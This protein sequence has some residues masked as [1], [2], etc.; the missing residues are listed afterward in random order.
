MTWFSRLRNWQ[1]DASNGIGI[2]ADYHDSEDDNFATGINSSLNIAGLNSP[3]A[4]IPMGGFKFTG[5]TSGTATGDSATFG[6]LRSQIQSGAVKWGGVTTGSSNAYVCSLSPAL[7]S[8]TN[9]LQLAVQASFTNSGAA[10]INVDGL[11]AKNIT[12]NGTTSLVANDILINGVIILTYDGTEFQI[13]VS[14]FTAPLSTKGDLFTFDGSVN[15]R[16]PIGSNGQ[17]LLADS[18]QTTGNKWG[19]VI[20]SVSGTAPISS[21]TT[22]GA[23]TVTY[24][25]AVTSI[26]GTTNIDASYNGGLVVVTSGT[27][28]ITFTAAATLTSGFSVSITNNGTGVVTL[29]PN[30]SETIDTY[31]TIQLTQGQSVTL[32]CTGSAFL[33]NNK[34]VYPTRTSRQIFTSGSAQTWTVP[35]GVYRVYVELYGGGGGGCTQNTNY[36]GGGG[37]GGYCDVIQA[38]TPGSGITYTVGAGGA[39]GVGSGSGSAGTA[40]TWSQ[41]SL[42]AGGGAGGTSTVVVAGGTATGGDINI[43]GG[44]G[45]PGGLNSQVTGVSGGCAGRYGGSGVGGMSL[46]GTGAAGQTYGG[47]GGGTFNTGQ[48]GG[49]GAGGLIVVWY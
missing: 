46:S 49:V 19:T 25:R 10:T 41:G 47:G 2:R 38:V 45:L 21:S 14:T 1:T 20:T 18:T 35:A 43:N 16:L 3:T 23:A 42:S 32:F 12:K 39:A 37:G 6:Q 29:D 30:A 34:S 5:L 36:G 26:S 31:T 22:A 28:S 8:Y 9:G 13:S 17:G 15:A 48:V 44:S 24:G 11:G 40:S 27:F 33:S 7:G 4:N